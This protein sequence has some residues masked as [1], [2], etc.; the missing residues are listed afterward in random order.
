MRIGSIDESNILRALDI[1][2]H[3]LQI[4]NVKSVEDVKKIINYSKYPPLGKRGFSPF[5]RAGN[6]SINNA[7]KLSKNANNNTLLAINIEGAEA[8]RNIDSILEIDGLDII[9]VGL[10]D[11]SNYLG[12]PGQV[13]SKEVEKLLSEITNKINDK[14]K[15]AGTITTNKDDIK[16]YLNMGLKY[17]VHLVDCEILK[18]SYTNYIDYFHEQKEK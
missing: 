2:I 7:S 4:P 12:I 10:Y 17:I 3:C 18:S 8:I 9:F 5:T 1:G 13:N 15:I 6:Y 11:I 14:N 16:R